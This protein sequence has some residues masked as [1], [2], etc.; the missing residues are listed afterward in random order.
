MLSVPG[1]SAWLPFL[2]MLP[3]QLLVRNL[4]YN[5]SQIG[6]SFDNVNEEYL[7]EPRQWNVPAI[8]R[9]ILFR[10]PCRPCSTMPP[11]H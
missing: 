2:P 8:A 7:K 9:F 4:L 1:T 5:F 3:V 10:G 6:I 11:S